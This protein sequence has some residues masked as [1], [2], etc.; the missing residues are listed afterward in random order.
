MSSPSMYDL[1][2]ERHGLQWPSKD[3]LVN[4]FHFWTIHQNHHPEKIIDMLSHGMDFQSICDPEHVIVANNQAFSFPMN[5]VGSKNV[6]SDTKTGIRLWVHP[7]SVV[8][9]AC[10]SMQ[11]WNVPTFAAMFFYDRMMSASK[12]ER[13]FYEMCYLVYAPKIS[14]P[15]MVTEAL[16]CERIDLKLLVDHI[17]QCDIIDWGKYECKVINID[18]N[19]YLFCVLRAFI[20]Y[21]E[22]ITAFIEYKHMARAHIVVNNILCI[23]FKFVQDLYLVHMFL[24]WF[25]HIYSVPEIFP[26]IKLETGQTQQKFIVPAQLFIH[27]VLSRSDY[28]RNLATT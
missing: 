3:T 7:K 21:A 11:H 28:R 9:L 23:K 27:E 4:I 10:L 6:I 5:V 14:H 26:E 24:V 12:T 1:I 20:A 22:I 15:P 18:T 16:K 25:T 8:A 13:Q 17:N 2:N 19:S